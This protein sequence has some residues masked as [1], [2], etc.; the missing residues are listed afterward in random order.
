MNLLI[1]IVSAL[2]STMPLVALS[3]GDSRKQPTRI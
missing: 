2:V 3:A 1:L